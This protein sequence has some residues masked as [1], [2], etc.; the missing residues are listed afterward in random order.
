MRFDEMRV[1]LTAER[2]RTVSVDD[3]LRY[4]ELTGDRNPV[5]VDAAAAAKT[6]FGGQIAHGMLSAGYISAVLGMDL[7]GPGSIYVAQTIRF[8]RPV[9]PGDT[10]TARV[11]VTDVIDAKRRVKLATTCRNQQGEIVLEGEA[12]ILMPE[13]SE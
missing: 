12:T 4:A 2:S 10:V 1:G 5:H 8:A 6:R 3:V 9:R 7:P 13:E 11:E